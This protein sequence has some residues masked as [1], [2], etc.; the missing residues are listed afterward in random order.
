MVCS[1]QVGAMGLPALSQTTYGPWPWRNWY[2][3]QGFVPTSKNT[4][5]IYLPTIN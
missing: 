5:S 3:V 2:L 4:S 1:S